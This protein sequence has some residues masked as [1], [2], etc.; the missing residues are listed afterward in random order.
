MLIPSS[1]QQ[2]KNGTLFHVSLFGKY[3]LNEELFSATT[4]E[5]KNVVFF[6]FVLCT[7]SIYDCYNSSGLKDITNLEAELNIIL[8]YCPMLIVYFLNKPIIYL[9]NK[10]SHVSRSCKC[11]CV[12]NWLCMVHCW[13][14]ASTGCITQNASWQAV[15]QSAVNPWVTLAN[16]GQLSENCTCKKIKNK[17]I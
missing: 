12:R 6:V 17:N 11:C 5:I 15:Q 7:F 1:Y 8:S 10:A 3:Q 13:R 16:H 4:E 9:L 14:R 2:N